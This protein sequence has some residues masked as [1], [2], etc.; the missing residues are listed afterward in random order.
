MKSP[1]E[2]AAEGLKVGDRFT[3]VRCFSDDDIRQFARISRDYNPVHCDTRY[4]QLCRFKAP[5]APWAS[6]CQPGHRNWRADWLAGDRDEFRV[7]KSR[8]RGTTDYLP[9]AHR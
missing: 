6:D 2:C 5:I 4:A 1:R 8:L 9:L 7:Q 3:V